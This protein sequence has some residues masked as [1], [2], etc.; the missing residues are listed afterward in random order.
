MIL[1]DSCC[2]EFWLATLS[3]VPEPLELPV[4]QAVAAVEN[5]A[6]ADDPPQ[7]EDPLPLH[8]QPV[9]EAAAEANMPPLPPPPSPPS[10]PEMNS[11]GTRDQTSTQCMGPTAEISPSPEPTPATAVDLPASQSASSEGGG[12]RGRWESDGNDKMTL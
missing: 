5:A 6:P 12:R 8:N 2:S 3:E 4:R 11:R 7:P 1:L 9:F 10:S